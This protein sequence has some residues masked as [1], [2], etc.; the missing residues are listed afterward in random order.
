MNTATNTPA[1][2]QTLAIGGGATMIGWSDRQACT[3][4]E[5][6]KTGRRV[7]VQRDTATL[8]NGIKSGAEDALTCHSGGFAA[9]VSGTQ[10]YSYEANPEARR[11]SYTLRKNGRFVMVGQP[12][13]GGPELTVNG[14]REHYDYNF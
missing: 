9:H 11:V 7:T 6:S 3:I 4:V 12:A 1:A 10:R 5:V 14:R 2:A 13:K 8:L